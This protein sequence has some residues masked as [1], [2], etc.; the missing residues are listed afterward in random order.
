MKI[1]KDKTLHFNA[2]LA[3]AI[4]F[5]V[6]FGAVVGLLLAVVAGIGKEVY[7]YYT[8]KGTPEIADVMYTW[9]GGAVG[10]IITLLL[11]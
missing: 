2:G 6:F 3:I 1:A 5:G 10:F 8:E 9:F 7:D 4:V 11:M